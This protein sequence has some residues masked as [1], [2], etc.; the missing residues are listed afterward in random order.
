MQRPESVL[1]ASLR[2]QESEVTRGV[3]AA[4]GSVAPALALFT[5]QLTFV[6]VCCFLNALRI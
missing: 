3:V 2:Y 5:D 4:W 6:E 1:V